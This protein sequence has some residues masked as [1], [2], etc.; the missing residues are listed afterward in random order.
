MMN[1][2]GL[3]LKSLFPGKILLFL[4]IVIISR[5]TSGQQ[6]QEAPVLSNP[7]SYT[8]ILIPDMQ[9]YQKFERNQPI[10]QL[11]V[12]WIKDQRVNLNIQMVFCTGDLTDRGN[13]LAYDSPDKGDQSTIEQWKALSAAFE[14]LDGLVPYIMCTGNHDYGIKI[15]ENRYS[16][17]NSFFPPQRNPK[18]FS[19]LTEMTE[20]DQGVKTLENA[21][22]EWISPLQ[23]KFMIFSLEFAP[24]KEVVDWA[25]SVAAQP[26]FRD[27]VGVLLTHSYLDTSGIRLVSNNYPLPDMNSGEALWQKLV[28]P[29]GNFRFVFSGHI[30]HSDAHTGMVGYS[31]DRDTLNNTVHQIMFNAQREGGGHW[32]NGGDGWLRI[33][34]FLPDKKTMK[35]STFSPLFYISPA[36][37]HLSWRKQLSDEFTLVY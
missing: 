6:H 36:T 34:E 3:K 32:G 18:T 5:S 11:M 16:H 12:N 25:K 31:A 28:K 14:K 17:F 10:L 29:S 24:R 2:P 26:R 9:N 20:N 23:Q 37:R 27:H 33:L 35:V 8:W 22:Y 15:A 4:I 1:T 19:L 13:I 7:G 30:C 21:C